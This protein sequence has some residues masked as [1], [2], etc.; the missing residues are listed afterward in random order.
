ML[1]ANDVERRYQDASRLT[2]NSL[3]AVAL[4]QKIQ[5]VSSL[6][7]PE[8]ENIIQRIARTIPAGNVPGVILNGLARLSGRRPP[9]Q[10]IRR[11]LNLLF[12]GVEQTIDHLV[13]AT[14][15]AGPA[16]VFMGYQK[17]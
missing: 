10:T 7:L 2:G 6:S 4:S 12:K 14:F 9:A 13:Y 11:D 16:A 1:E 15:F 5:E 3:K 17:L 8:I